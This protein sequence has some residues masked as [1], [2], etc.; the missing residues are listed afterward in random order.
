HRLEL[1]HHDRRLSSGLLLQSILMMQP[2]QDWCTHHTQVRCKSV[3]VRLSQYRQRCRWRGN[4]WS[5]GDVRTT[6]IIMW[7]PCVQEAAQV[8]C[9]EGKHEVQVFSPQR[10]N[11]PLAERIRLRRPHRCLEHP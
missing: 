7:H 4:T 11:E 2:T 3:P 5:Q 1:R 9:R 10:A 8:I 6:S